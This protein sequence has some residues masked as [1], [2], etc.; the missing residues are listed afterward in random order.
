MAFTLFGVIKFSKVGEYPGL[1]HIVSYGA[2]H[3][4]LWSMALFTQ[5]IGMRTSND[6]VVAKIIAGLV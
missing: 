5:T 6:L 4:G 1:L 2:W 3:I